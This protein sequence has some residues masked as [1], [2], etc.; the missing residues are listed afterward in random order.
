VGTYRDRNDALLKGLLPNDVALRAVAAHQN[1][2]WVTTTT[3]GRATDLFC[4]PPHHLR[5]MTGPRA[6]DEKAAVPICLF[7]DP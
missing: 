2:E 6:G 5:V 1:A 3:G 7:V 4:V